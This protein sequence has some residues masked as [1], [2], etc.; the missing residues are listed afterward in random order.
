MEEEGKWIGTC[1]LDRKEGRKEGYARSP[2]KRHIRAG[3]LQVFPSAHSK[4]RACYAKL[5]A[6]NARC[7]ILA[8]TWPRPSEALTLRN[9]RDRTLIPFPFPQLPFDSDVSLDERPDFVWLFVRAFRDYF[10][11]V[12]CLYR[13][14]IGWDCNFYFEATAWKSRSR[15]SKD[16]FHSVIRILSTSEEDEI[17]SRVTN[18]EKQEKNVTESNNGSLWSFAV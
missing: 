10:L 6:C 8:H 14:V 13:I 3:S 18:D 5:E 2:P 15:L 11:S 17:K 12:S 4:P 7:R 1:E 9:V 16:C